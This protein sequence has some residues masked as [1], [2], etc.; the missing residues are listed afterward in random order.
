ME[1]CILVLAL[2]TAFYLYTSIYI[3]VATLNHNVVYYNAGKYMY[4]HVY[5]TLFLAIQVYTSYYI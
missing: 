3:Y 2:I 1:M 4:N 5:Y